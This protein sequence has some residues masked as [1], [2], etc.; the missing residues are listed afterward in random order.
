[1]KI[2]TLPLAFCCAFLPGDETD[3]NTCDYLFSGRTVLAAPVARIIEEEV[4]TGLLES[5]TDVPI[6]FDQFDPANGTL[7][8]VEVG[9]KITR[10][11]SFDL[12][13]TSS[14]TNS[15][16]IGVANGTGSFPFGFDIWDAGHTQGSNYQRVVMSRAGEFSFAHSNYHPLL[17]QRIAGG[18]SLLIEQT[19]AESDYTW[20]GTITDS[21]V[22]SALTGTGTVEVEFDSNYVNGYLSSGSGFSLST[23]YELTVEAAI[24]Y[25]Y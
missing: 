20:S 25:N 17:L 11:N 2:L 1:M 9:L 21:S 12:G 3:L 24:R 16:G 7:T 4:V 23:T 5:D 18:D 22:L 13:N 10:T 6:D 19:D 14:S 8:S 15:I